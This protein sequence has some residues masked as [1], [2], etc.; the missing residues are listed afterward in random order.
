MVSMIGIISSRISRLGCIH[1][2]EIGLATP[3]AQ[4]RLISDSRVV[5][6][7][8]NRNLLVTGP[9]MNGAFSWTTVRTA[10][11]ARTKPEATARLMFAAMFETISL[12]SLSQL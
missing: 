6:I 5:G 10:H 7:P 8:I 9:K 3:K 2:P 12:K 11:E 4:H 1:A